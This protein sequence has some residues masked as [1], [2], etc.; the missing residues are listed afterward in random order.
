ME[1]VLAEYLR[2]LYIAPYFTLAVSAVAL[3]AVS[4]TL[5]DVA[6]GVARRIIK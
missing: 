4:M 1:Q 3:L 5:V 6:F 2:W